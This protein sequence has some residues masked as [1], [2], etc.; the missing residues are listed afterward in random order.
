MVGLG[1]AVMESQIH[2]AIIPLVICL[3]VQD[4]SYRRFIQIQELKAAGFCAS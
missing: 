1:S 4:L 2:I 3:L